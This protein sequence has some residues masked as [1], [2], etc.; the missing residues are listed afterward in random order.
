M[1]RHK[2]GAGRRRKGKKKK[3]F[4]SSEEFSG[5]LEKFY[6]GTIAGLVCQSDYITD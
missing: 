6:Y 2:F 4:V 5:Y 3:E 1:Q